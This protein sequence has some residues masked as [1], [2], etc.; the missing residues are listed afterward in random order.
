MVSCSPDGISKWG[1]EVVRRVLL[2]WVRDYRVS[3]RV[4]NVR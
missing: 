1:D 4:S 3:S 2:L